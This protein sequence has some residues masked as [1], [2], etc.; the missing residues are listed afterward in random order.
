MQQL[1]SKPG[2]VSPFW[3][4]PSSASHL[5]WKP[6]LR[7]CH[8]T[9][10]A[11]WPDIAEGSSLTLSSEQGKVRNLI[12]CHADIQITAYSTDRILSEKTDKQSDRLI[13]YGEPTPESVG[14]LIEYT[15]ELPIQKML[16]MADKSVTDELRPALYEALNGRAEITVAIPGML[17]VR[18][19]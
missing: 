10:V 17:E 5:S 12:L 11:Q 16:V 4:T 14:G 2:L 19:P 7:A 3:S 6:E 8:L 13:F 1:S 15:K 18:Y 9:S